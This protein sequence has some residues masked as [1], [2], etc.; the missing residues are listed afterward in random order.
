MAAGGSAADAACAALAVLNVVEPQSSGVGGG[1]FALVHGTEGL[2][3]WDARETAPAGAAPDMFMENGEP[4]PFRAAVASGRSI[5]VP[6]LVRLME[7]L[8]AGHG[9]LP[10]TDLFQPR[11]S[12][13][14]RRVRG[15]RVAGRVAGSIRRAL[16][17]NGCRGSLSATRQA[18]G[19]G[20][21]PEAATTRRDV[22]NHCA[23]GANA[24]YTG[25]LAER[26]VAKARR[27]RAPAR[28]AWTISLPTASS[29]A[30][31]SVIH[32]ELSRLRHGPAFLGGDH[33]RPDPDAPRSVQ[34]R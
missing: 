34:V 7:A 4:L 15:E 19:G 24:F 33:D 32:F 29:N 21:A 5:G 26:I 9:K 27:A 8:H 22:R 31:R 10:W 1:A 12:V 25:P 17:R 2:T 18:T 14:A 28:S 3:T 6:G 13:G 23:Q 16:G 11:D 30:L 20:S